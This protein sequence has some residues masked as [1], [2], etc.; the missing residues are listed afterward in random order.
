MS[1]P[2]TVSS[3]KEL[4][5]HMASRFPHSG[6]VAELVQRSG[7]SRQE[8]QALLRSEAE[9]SPELLAAAISMFESQEWLGRQL[10]T[11]NELPFSGLPRNIGK[12]NAE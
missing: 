6:R 4:A 3:G 12:L 7:S 2:E 10:L 11:D 1:F 9:P 5:S 8:V